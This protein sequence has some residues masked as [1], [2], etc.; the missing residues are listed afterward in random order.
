MDEMV[1][2]YRH[3]E[4]SRT[5]TITHTSCGESHVT[6]KGIPV[7]LLETTIE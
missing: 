2:V 6:G 3:R 5:D 4:I 1:L 7:S